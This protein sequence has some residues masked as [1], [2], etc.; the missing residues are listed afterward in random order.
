MKLPSEK[1]DV[2]SY[3]YGATVRRVK[4]ISRLQ[5]TAP[6]TF[7]EMGGLIGTKFKR[8]K[9]RRKHCLEEE[10]EAGLTRWNRACQ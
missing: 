4:R 1:R 10:G 5:E 6:V 3:Q 7:V 2:T 9:K 8:K